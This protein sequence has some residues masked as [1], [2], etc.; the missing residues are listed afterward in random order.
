MLKINHNYRRLHSKWFRRSCHNIIIDDE[1]FI[2]SKKLNEFIFRNK[3]IICFVNV[4][5]NPRLL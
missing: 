2:I 5:T 4:E 1:N 3:I